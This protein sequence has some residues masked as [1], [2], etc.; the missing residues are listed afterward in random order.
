MIVRRVLPPRI[1]I[2][3]SRAHVFANKDLELSTLV[4]SSKTMRTGLEVFATYAGLL[5][6]DFTKTSLGAFEFLDTRTPG[7]IPDVVVESR[8]AVME[9][10]VKRLQMAVFVSACIFGRHAK[11]TNSSM[12]KPN[13]PGLDEVFDW[14]KDDDG[15]AI[16]MLKHENERLS[17]YLTEKIDDLRRGQLGRYAIP[18]K[19][20]I[21]GVEC[22]DRLI[23][24]AQKSTVSDYPSLL[25]M[26]YQAS[27]LHNR[28]HA[29]ASIALCATI[30]EVLVH[31]LFYLAGLV[32]GKPK[33]SSF[34]LPHSCAQISKKHLKEMRSGDRLKHLKSGGLIDSY[35]FE[36]LDSV[37]RIRNGLLH[38]GEDARCEASGNALT[39]IRDLIKICTDEELE[40]GTHWTY[41]I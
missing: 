7:I 21:E 40:L 33:E 29:G 2:V 30:T 24:S 36:R 37:R 35:L 19:H 14:R 15:Q 41:R 4:F 38:R 31:E 32:S 12:Q 8:E 25:E 13:Y 28:Q 26:S 6:F 18:E 3:P 39:A 17:V 16:F 11:L 10:Q 20:F 22:A 34:S 5:A 27:I 23:A 9:L 1:A